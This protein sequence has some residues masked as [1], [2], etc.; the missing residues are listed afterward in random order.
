MR[1]IWYGGW[2]VRATLAFL[3]IAIPVVIVGTIAHYIRQSW[4]KRPQRTEQ[5]RRGDRIGVWILLG[6]VVIVL[7]VAAGNLAAD[8]FLSW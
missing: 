7:L 5:E 1:D 6:A 4:A 2:E 3:A 8:A